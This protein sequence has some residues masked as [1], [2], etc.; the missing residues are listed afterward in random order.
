MFSRI[1]SESVPSIGHFDK[2]VV[3]FYCSN[4]FATFLRILQ[5]TILLEKTSFFQKKIFVVSLCE[6]KHL[7]FTGKYGKIINSDIELLFVYKLYRC[8]FKIIILLSSCQGAYL[9]TYFCYLFID[10]YIFGL[11]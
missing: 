10:Y 5:R 7:F 1:T 8:W 6:E 9:M 3:E 11:R 2:I 4:I